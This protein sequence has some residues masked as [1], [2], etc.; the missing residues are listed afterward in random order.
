MTPGSVPPID[1][2][3]A[4]SATWPATATWTPGPDARSA[5]ATNCRATETGTFWASLSKVTVAKAVVAPALTSADPP[6]RYGLSTEV[7]NGR[8]PTRSSIGSTRSLTAG[9]VT[10]LPPVV[11]ITICSRSPAMAGADDRSRLR[12]CVEGVSGSEKLF[13]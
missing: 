13:V 11:W 5:V 1:W 3:L 4:S 12:A 7:T 9:S 10:R 8:V 6:G 2:R